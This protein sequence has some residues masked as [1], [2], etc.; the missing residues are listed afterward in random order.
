MNGRLTHGDGYQR[1]KK[2]TEHCILRLVGIETPG[3]LD[4][5]V[6]HTAIYIYKYL[7]PVGVCTLYLSP[8]RG[9]RG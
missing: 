6:L 7:M 1:L 8:K 5:E 3:T 2:C 4:S 9:N